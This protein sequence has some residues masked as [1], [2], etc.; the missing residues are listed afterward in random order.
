MK[1]TTKK[2]I[3]CDD[4]DRLIMETYDKQYCVQQQDGCR[5][6]G[7][8]PLTIPVTWTGD[9]LMHDEIPI[10]I[11]G[12]E[13]G[14]KFNVW[15]NRTEPFFEDENDES[16]FWDRNFYPDLDTLADDL[17]KRGLLEPGEYLIEIDW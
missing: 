6:R 7:F 1:H 3:N 16:L 11:N 12:R 14:V 15:L 5:P 4:W 9:E 13:K 8:L 2:I 17:H 10:K